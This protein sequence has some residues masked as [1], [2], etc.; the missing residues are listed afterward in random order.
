MPQYMVSNGQS[1]PK[2]ARID[3]N[4][5][6]AVWVDIEQATGFGTPEAAKEAFR[7]AV[8]RMEESARR[9]GARAVAEKKI[10]P[11]HRPGTQWMRKEKDDSWTTAKDPAEFF[12]PAWAW[13]A[14]SWLGQF[15]VGARPT[16]EDLLGVFETFYVRSGAGWL[17]RPQRKSSEGRLEWNESFA[18]AVPF[19]SMEDASARLKKENHAGSIV[20]T[21]CVFTEVVFDSARS[22]ADD[23][24]NMIAAAC[25]ARDI[26]SAIE[27][28]AS[29]RISAMNETARKNA[30][31]ASAGSTG[32]GEASAAE[33]E[34]PRRAARL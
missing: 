33:T 18:L 6:K 30:V 28:S 13:A 19:A 24:A 25:E 2:F 26:Q 34:K 15:T 7:G 4:G 32:S 10:V 14:K 22:R 27:Q 11:S 20:K 21:S 16:K 8:L 12:I 17:C 9:A 5:R 31:A 1:M 23:T 3:D 29:E